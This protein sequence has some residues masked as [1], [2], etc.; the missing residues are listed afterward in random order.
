HS[1][2]DDPSFWLTHWSNDVPSKNT[3]AS[4]GAPSGEVVTTRGSGSHTSVSS[5][6]IFVCCAKTGSVSS[7]ATPVIIIDFLSILIK[8]DNIVKQHSVK[9]W[10]KFLIYS[11]IS[12]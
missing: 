10:D 1:A 2:G 5:D 7:T 4:D 11:K 9:K 12:G 6:F 8:T 3:M